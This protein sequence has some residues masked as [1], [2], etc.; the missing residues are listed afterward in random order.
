PYIEPLNCH[1]LGHMN[2]VCPHCRAYHWITEHLVASSNFHPLF[3]KCCDQGQVH[4][5]LMHKPPKTLKSLW[6]NGTSD[7]IEFCMNVCCYNAAVT[8][9]FLGVEINHRVNM[10]GHHAPYAQWLK[11]LSQCLHVFH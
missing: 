5:P 10:Q 6:D 4:L 7:S 2:M 9:M 1:D 11:Q 8:F 3:R